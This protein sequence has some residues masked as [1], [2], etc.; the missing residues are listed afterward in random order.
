VHWSFHW[1]AR[2]WKGKIRRFISYLPPGV[3]LKKLPGMATLMAT[4]RLFGRVVDS[5][6]E[7]GERS[8]K[9]ATGRAETSCL[10]ESSLKLWDFELLRRKEKARRRPASSG[11]R[12]ELELDSG[13]L[14]SSRKHVGFSHSREPVRR[15]RL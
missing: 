1:A 4:C 14:I 13:V 3:E 2:S 9:L 15:S 5:R 11:Q 6:L 7:P 8:G 12:H 10:A